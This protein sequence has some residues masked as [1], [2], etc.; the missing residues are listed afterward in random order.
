M[1]LIIIY[2]VYGLSFFSMGLAVLLEVNRSSRLEYARAVYPLGW[3]GLVHGGHE[4]LEMFI[5]IYSD[6]QQMVVYHYIAPI[7]I[8]LLLVSFLFLID[9]GARLVF[10]ASATTSSWRL[11]LSVVGIWLVGCIWVFAAHPT[12]EAL[13]LID[14]YTRY[15][16]AIPGAALTAW[17]LVLQQ[18]RFT[19]IGMRGFGRDVIIA[20]I[21][22]GLYGAIGQLF[23]APSTIFPSQFINARVFLAVTGFPIQLFRSVMALVAAVAMISSLRAFE[24]ETQRQIEGLRES[25]QREQKQREELRAELLRR[26]VRAQESE[27]QRIARELHDELG[28]MLTALGLGLRAISNGMSANPERV[29]AQSKELLRLVDMCFNGLQN[30]ISGLH[31]PQLDDFGLVSTLRWYVQQVHARYGLSVHLEIQGRE[32]SLPP[33]ITVVLFRIIQEGLTNVIRH[34]GTDRAGVQVK[35]GQ[36]EI[37]IKV[38]DD[39]RGF[40]VDAV[41]Q[42]GDR[43]C[44]GLLGM[45]E[46]ARLV[47]GTCNFL[48]ETGAGT[49]V[50][51]CVPV[52]KVSKHAEHTTAPGG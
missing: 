5:I 40:D 41:L 27:R 9:F 8:G 19:Q 30:L 31:P 50:E 17:G 45:I 15:V 29:R 18:R 7:R 20:A 10:G 6:I 4:W 14:V 51:V 46:R 47:G 49:Q 22:F 43:P 16:L 33:D 32:T 38:E 24:A 2:F 12:D 35:F 36:G 52:N 11:L 1:D 25:Q 28:Q 34:A 48:S 44:W 39:G 37:C 13:I 3:F 26:T 42:R 21:A 23:V